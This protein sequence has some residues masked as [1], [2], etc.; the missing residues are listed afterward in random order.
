MHKKSNRVRISAAKENVT[1]ES[2]V[3]GNAALRICVEDNGKGMNF[4]MFLKTNSGLQPRKSGRI[5]MIRDIL[6]PMCWSRPM[7]QQKLKAVN[8]QC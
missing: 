7:S 6:H 1:E 5:G 8:M 3:K 4:S 2:A